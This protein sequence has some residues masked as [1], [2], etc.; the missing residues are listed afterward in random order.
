MA[1]E[2]L[3]VQVIPEALACP[4]FREDPAVPGFPAA[5][6][7]L[8]VQP[9]PEVPAGFVHQAQIAIG[10]VASMDHAIR[11]RYCRLH[12]H[13]E[14]SDCRTSYQT[15]DQ[16]VPHVFLP[17]HVR[18]TRTLNRKPQVIQMDSL[19]SSC[20]SFDPAAEALLSEGS[21]VSET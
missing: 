8:L 18:P 16:P 21:L 3:E 14:A 4:G 17:A 2:V 5:P 15:S 1:P 9:D 10:A 6:E 20:G 7:F 19:G 11:I 13:Q 12:D